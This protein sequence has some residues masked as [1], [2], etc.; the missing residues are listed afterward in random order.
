MSCWPGRC[1]RCGRATW[2]LRQQTRRHDRRTDNF[3]VA[4]RPPP[5]WHTAPT[6]PTT[7][8]FCTLPAHN[9]ATRL[10]LHAAAHASPSAAPLCT[11]RT[12][13][14]PTAYAPPTCPHRLHYAAHTHALLTLT[15]SSSAA[16]RSN[17]A[18]TYARSHLRSPR[19]N[20]HLSPCRAASGI[21]PRQRHSRDTLK[22]LP[23]SPYNRLL[24]LR[25]T[26]LAAS[27][28]L[29]LATRRLHARF[30]RTPSAF[31]TACAPG[32]HA[33]LPACAA[34]HYHARLSLLLLVLLYAPPLDL[35]PPRAL[36][37]H[38]TP[39]ASLMR[40]CSQQTPLLPLFAAMLAWR[41]TS[42]APTRAS[43]ASHTRLLPAA[44]LLLRLPAL[45]P[46]MPLQVPAGAPGRSAF[47]NKA[48]CRHARD[49]V[50]AHDAT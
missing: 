37:A 6:T 39:H 27:R 28:T 13:A 8:S 35:P 7:F 24:P 38:R 5:T 46:A 40:A 3:G 45:R 2:T 32:G 33:P 44:A 43:R 34:A 25:H 11:R 49:I 17:R 31:P 36:R 22:R 10:Y 50:V 41:L 48:H 12:P 29:T 23:T 1:W 30:S 14:P 15:R 9:Y 42:Y 21:T 18:L 47:L 16:Q 26:C 20:A 19:T 4:L